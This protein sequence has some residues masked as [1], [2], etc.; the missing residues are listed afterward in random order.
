M[1]KLSYRYLT[2]SFI[3]IV[4]SLAGC[5]TTTSTAG[6]AQV[7]R[8]TSTSQILE[9]PTNQLVPTAQSLQQPQSQQQRGTSISS[10]PI[11]RLNTEMHT[12]N[13]FR[14][15][16]DAAGRYVITGSFDKTARIWNASTG[17][18]IRILRIPIGQGNEGDV[19]GV[20]LSPDGT[21]ALVSG[22]TRYGESDYAIYFFDV[23]SGHITHHLSG[24][25]NTINDL[26]FSPDGRFI[27]VA[28][29]GTADL[30]VVDAQHRT[31]I[32][33][34]SGYE[35]D[36]YNV[37]WSP[38]GR[39]A[40]TSSDGLVRLYNQNFQ[41]V[42]STKLTGG[43]YPLHLSFS[44]DGRLLAVGFIDSN[45]LQIL[46]SRSLELLYE[47]DTSDV[48]QGRTIGSLAWSPDGSV[49]Y[50]GGSDSRQF[51]GIWKRYVRIWQQGGRGTYRDIG[52]AGNTILDLKTLNKGQILVTSAQPDLTVLEPSGTIRWQNDSEKLTY[53]V[54]DR[55][56]LRID[57]T[58]FTIGATPLSETAFT[59]RVSDRQLQSNQFTGS[60]FRGAVGGMRFSEW[61]NTQD[62]IALN[63]RRLSFLLTHEVSRSVDVA[64]NGQFGVLG[65]SWS[66]YGVNPDGSQAWRIPVPGTAWAVNIADNGRVFVAAYGD[67]TIRWHRT[68]DGQELMAFFL[69]SD[70]QRW[71]LWTPSGYYDASPGGEELIGWHVNRGVDGTPDFYP[72]STF[73][74]RFYRPDIIQEILVSYDEQS[75]VATA[76]ERRGVR[77]TTQ[78]ADVLPPTVRILNP[79]R[80][81]QITGQTLILEVEISTANDAPVTD[82]QVRVNGR[83]QHGARG[84]VVTP[85]SREDSGSFRRIPIDL[86]QISGSE[87]FITVQASNRHGI[88]PAADVQ[89]RLA[90][91]GFQE[92][93]VA[94]KLYVLAVGVSNYSDSSLNLMYAAKDARD[95]SSLW[96]QQA[97]GLYRQVEVRT[98]TDSDAT[99]QAIRDG[100]FWLEEQVTAN[101]MAIIFI[102]GHGIN[103]NTGLLH[104]APY[105]VD[106]SRLRRTGLPATEIVDTVSY[107]QGRVIYFM[108]ACHSGNLDFVR[109]SLGGVDLNRHIQDL[110]AA[111][112]GAVVFSSAAGSQFALE[113]P[114]WGNGAFTRAKIEGLRGAADYNRDGAVS[115]NELNLYVSEAVKALTN[116]QQTPVMQRPNSIRDFPLTTV[117]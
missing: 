89:V 71:V 29:G 49:L 53:S 21:T 98:L 90:G 81:A 33:W 7:A 72:A 44:P 106:V 68:S 32:H 40:T 64:P 36:S 108:D 69:H 37:A 116:N 28:T 12:S 18:L 60:F 115:V 23:S 77:V 4:G 87:G 76:N 91:R 25:G 34:L 74:D 84:L 94:P 70:R 47:P 113:S 50:A 17:E 67:G 56:H 8:S 9:E 85:Q 51:N 111:E 20:A 95:V 3:I 83:P 107:L 16:S 45:R 22:W 110:S 66:V 101:D 27:A 112:T 80:D 54:A 13:G 19:R 117:R 10:E 15:D 103:D 82:I 52:I 73:R 5:N 46:D 58:G 105:D 62:Q 31:I 1:K 100:L 109:R 38:D 24:F 30:A 26:E 96:Q 114:Q 41:L 39:L 57:A 11:L 78:I 102:A 35:A 75:A 2:L 14:V 59:L 6:Q 88:G 86:S 97:G 65:T 55:S 104:F 93:V 61:T 48:Q 99:L 43:A 92:F 63:G 79:Q 42:T